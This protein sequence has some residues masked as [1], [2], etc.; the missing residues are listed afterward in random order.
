MIIWIYQNKNTNVIFI[1][2]LGQSNGANPQIKFANT[3][4]FTEI[5]LVKPSEINSRNF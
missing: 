4:S 3:K 2:R 1:T 5:N